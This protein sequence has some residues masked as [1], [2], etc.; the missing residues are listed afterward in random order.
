[1]TRGGGTSTMPRQGG[2]RR[3]RD[4]RAKHKTRKTPTRKTQTHLVEVFGDVAES[5]LARNPAQQLRLRRFGRQ[6]VHRPG[7]AVEDVGDGD[8]AAGRG[9]EEVGDLLDLFVFVS[10]CFVLFR[11]VWRGVG[12]CVVCWCVFTARH[13]CARQ[14]QQTTWCCRA[15]WRA[16]RA[17]AGS[18]GG[19]RCPSRR[20]SRRAWCL[21][22]GKWCFE[23]PAA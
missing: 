10:F 5:D 20:R 11:F 23:A 17:P 9:A 22:A 18:P 2:H 13:A 7:L 3:E 14:R 19:R 1:M 12:L 16:R 8:G 4:R 15:L 6:A 21:G